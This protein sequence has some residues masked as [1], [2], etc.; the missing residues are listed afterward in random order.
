MK[1][2][3]FINQEKRRKF[4]QLFFGLTNQ[5]VVVFGGITFSFIIAGMITLLKGK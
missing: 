5:M 2:E 3:N 4:L 1:V